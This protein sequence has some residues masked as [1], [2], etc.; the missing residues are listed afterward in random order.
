[1]KNSKLF[2]NVDLNKIN[3]QLLTK[4]M[5]K[6]NVHDEY[7]AR[8]LFV[9]VYQRIVNR[10]TDRKIYFWSDKNKIGYIIE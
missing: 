5:N 1:M 9:M 3:P 8:Y 6:Y 7:D 2:M 10:Q 4:F